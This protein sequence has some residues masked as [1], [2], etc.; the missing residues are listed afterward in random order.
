MISSKGKIKLNEFLNI[1]KVCRHLTK[2]F[3]SMAKLKF[4]KDSKDNVLKSGLAM[5]SKDGEYV[6]LKEPC[7]LNGRVIIYGFYCM[8]CVF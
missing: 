7:D 3:D 1:F 8:E 6:D 2:L 5:W 4:A